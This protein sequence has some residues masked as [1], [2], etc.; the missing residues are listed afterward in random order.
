MHLVIAHVWTN[1]SCSSSAVKA[2]HQTIGWC[3]AET[4]VWESIVMSESHKQAQAVGGTSAPIALS[5]LSIR[6]M[7]SGSWNSAPG[8]PAGSMA[9]EEIAGVWWGASLWSDI[10]EAVWGAVKRRTQKTGVRRPKIGA[11]RCSLIQ[12]AMQCECSEIC[13]ENGVRRGTSERL[14]PSRRGE[15]PD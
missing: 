9:V 14:S 8:A 11:G 7:R 6:T 10:L 1:L 13:R 4:T 2:F 15:S 5:S 3:S 12:E